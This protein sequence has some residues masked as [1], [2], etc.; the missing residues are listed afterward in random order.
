MKNKKNSNIIFTLTKT[1]IQS[2]LT[3]AF[4]DVLTILILRFVF[5]EPN[6]IE[7]V[8]RLINNVIWCTLIIIYSRLIKNPKIKKYV[9]VIAVL[10]F[11]VEQFLVCYKYIKL[12]WVFQ[13]G[14]VMTKKT[15]VLLSI[16]VTSLIV[17]RILE[18][19][20]NISSKIPIISV[21]LLDCIVVPIIFLLWQYKE[22]IP[23]QQ[24]FKE[25]FVWILI[26][27]MKIALIASKIYGLINMFL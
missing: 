1:V 25:L 5:D 19:I 26:F 17:A 11:A 23:E 24:F 4:V 12:W 13:S 20:F 21:L 22:D 18:T 2:L 16:S 6:V 3:V 14:E 7:F 8:V 9:I 27:T 10:F 15:N